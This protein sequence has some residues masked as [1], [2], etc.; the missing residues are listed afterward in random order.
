MLGKPTRLISRLVDPDEEGDIPRYP[1]EPH[2]NMARLGQTGEGLSGFG[3]SG[4]DA[5]RYPADSNVNIARQS[6]LVGGGPGF[7]N[8]DEDSYRYPQHGDSVRPNQ[9]SGIIEETPR[10]VPYVDQVQSQ[11]QDGR[12]VPRRGVPTADAEYAPHYNYDTE[13]GHF[14]GPGPG[15]EPKNAGPQINN[16]EERHNRNDDRIDS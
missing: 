15:P 7:G 3:N 11:S 5:P 12:Y 9:R 6:Y 8:P 16:W 13:N 10:Y 2:V 1:P 4:D 14:V